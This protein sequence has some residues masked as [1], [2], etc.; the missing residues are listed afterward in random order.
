MKRIILCILGCILLMMWPAQAENDCA[1][2]ERR[3]VGVINEWQD[4]ESGHQYVETQLEIC[5]ACGEKCFLSDS[6]DL[7]GHV[8][9]MSESIHFEAENRHLCVLICPTCW[10]VELS[11]IICPGGD[12]CELFTP[13]AGEMPPIQQGESLEEMYELTTPD[14]IKRW[15]AQNRDE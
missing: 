8:F 14:Y 15:L 11:E 10:H 12:V 2:E 13:Q 6:G 9:H 5:D 7:E 3:L 1:H 4:W